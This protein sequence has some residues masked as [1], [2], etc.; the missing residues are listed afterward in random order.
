MTLPK[1]CEVKIPYL[2]QFYKSKIGALYR[3]TE[4]FR[5]EQPARSEAFDAHVRY[6]E[7]TIKILR[8]V[9]EVIGDTPT[10]IY[11]SDTGFGLRTS[12]E[13]A[14]DLVEKGLARPSSF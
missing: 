5:G 7:E 13:I 11:A 14:D 8:Q 9:Q 1:S 4:V 3:K 12:A 10:E 6:L 2:D